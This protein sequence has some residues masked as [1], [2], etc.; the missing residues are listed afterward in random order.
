VIHS[1]GTIVANAA[2]VERGQAP[3]SAA[4]QTVSVNVSGQDHLVSHQP[5]ESNLTHS[6][7]YANGQCGL[8]GAPHLGDANQN[9]TCTDVV[10]HGSDEAVPT[11]CPVDSCAV[12]LGLQGICHNVDC[13]FHLIIAKKQPVQIIEMSRS[14]RKSLF[15]GWVRRGRWSKSQWAA[16][17]WLRLTADKAELLENVVAAASK[18]SDK[19]RRVV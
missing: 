9:I 1:T 14:L 13:E 3:V 8:P 12:Q 18:K 19:R 17:K 16:N 5:L 4:G 7:T 6:T 10:G 2:R 11:V 15:A